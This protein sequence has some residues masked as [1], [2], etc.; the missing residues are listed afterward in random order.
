MPS[1]VPHTC[2]HT[3]NQQH[4]HTKTH[5]P[6]IHFKRI[7]F[8]H[9]MLFKFPYL[10]A[11]TKT[12]ANPKE[13]V[14]SLNFNKTPSLSSC[15][16]SLAQSRPVLSFL[17]ETLTICFC[18]QISEVLVYIVQDRMKRWRNTVGTNVWESILN[19]TI[20]KAHKIKLN[21]ARVLSL[22]TSGF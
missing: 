16:E 9:V 19:A 5:H 2:S 4:T 6:H 3:K 22:L 21:K 18:Y 20:S 11:H 10:F 1:L 17:R 8:V 15:N 12:C 14:F 7:V 13:N